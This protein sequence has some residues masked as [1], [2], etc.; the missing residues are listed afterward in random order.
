[1]VSDTEQTPANINPTPADRAPNP[2]D[3]VTTE[4][5]PTDARSY[6]AEAQKMAR[7]MNGLR[8]YQHLISSK[9]G[10]ETVIPKEEYL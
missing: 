8:S 10:V 9:N 4:D 2:D 7:I 5:T 6:A 3:M 1:M